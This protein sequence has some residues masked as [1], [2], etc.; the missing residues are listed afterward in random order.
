MLQKYHSY[1]STTS[2]FPDVL[3]DN[4]TGRF[5]LRFFALRRRLDIF[6]KL[7]R[8]GGDDDAIMQNDGFVFVD[9]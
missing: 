6:F 2:N 5:K 3:F 7:C 1:R 8:V 4:S 9:V